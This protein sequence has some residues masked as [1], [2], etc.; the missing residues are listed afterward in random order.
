MEKTKEDNLKKEEKSSPHFAQVINYNKEPW[1]TDIII[2]QKGSK[3][4]GHMTLS[5]NV[6]LYLRDEEGKEIIKQ[7]F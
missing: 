3:R 7:E 2:G 4:H 6:I 1:L 5:G